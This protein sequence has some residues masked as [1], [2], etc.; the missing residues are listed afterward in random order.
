MIAEELHAHGVRLVLRHKPRSE[1][2]VAHDLLESGDF[3]RLQPGARLDMEI[4]WYGLEETLRHDSSRLCETGNFRLRFRLRLKCR[5]LLPNPRYFRIG[6][7]GFVRTRTNRASRVFAGRLDR[8]AYSI[9]FHRRLFRRVCFRG[10]IKRGNKRHDG[11]G[12]VLSELVQLHGT[13]RSTCGKRAT[14]FSNALRHILQRFGC[15]APRVILGTALPFQR[16]GFLRELLFALKETGSVLRLQVL[17]FRLPGVAVAFK[18]VKVAVGNIDFSNNFRPLF[19]KFALLCSGLGEIDVRPSPCRAD[20]ALLRPKERIASALELAEE[21]KARLDAVE[22]FTALVDGSKPVDKTGERLAIRLFEQLAEKLVEVPRLRRDFAVRLAGRENAA[23]VA[24][25]FDIVEETL[26]NGCRVLPD[27]REVAPGGKRLQ[28]LCELVAKGRT[29]LR[30]AVVRILDHQRQVGDGS[31][32]HAAP[33]VVGYVHASRRKTHAN[34]HRP[35]SFK[36][37]QFKGGV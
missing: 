3:R 24:V 18:G 31:V 2:R 7:L 11:N 8:R 35:A 16:G 36:R 15:L 21:S 10:G 30:L 37:R 27:L 34:R 12:R 1:K 26:R 13:F 17:E 9:R 20:E 32:R 22:A 28:A 5:E 14:R 19:L 4:E 6:P 25:C 23:D 33:A 29:A